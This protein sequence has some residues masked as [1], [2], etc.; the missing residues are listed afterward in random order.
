MPVLETFGT[1]ATSSP[2]AHSAIQLW[3]ALPRNPS[4]GV[5]YALSI[6]KGEKWT[7]QI[8]SLTTLSDSLDILSK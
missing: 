6:L 5:S 1:I 2:T 7:V 8:E 3:D 4:G